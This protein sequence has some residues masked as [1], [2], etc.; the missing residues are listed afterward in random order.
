MESH[1][2]VILNPDGKSWIVTDQGTEKVSLTG[3][4]SRGWRPVRETPFAGSNTMS[5]VDT[6]IL[7]LL[8][9]DQD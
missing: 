5:Y 3:L 1:L 6:Y 4:L 2:Y 8:A 9:R 7:I